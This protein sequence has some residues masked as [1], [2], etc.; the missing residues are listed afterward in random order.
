MPEL[1]AVVYIQ[2]SPQKSVREIHSRNFPENRLFY[3]SY[4]I[5]GLISENGHFKAK[6]WYKHVKM[7]HSAIF[8]RFICLNLLRIPSFYSYW[9]LRKVI[10][11]LIITILRRPISV[12][13]AN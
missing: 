3:V 11:T 7:M 9:H 8:M 4:S 2:D 13:V 12:N 6:I 10:Y 1:T 5:L